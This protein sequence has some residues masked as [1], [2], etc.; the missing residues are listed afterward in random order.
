MQV[1]R[2]DDDNIQSEP[3]KWKIAKTFL[4]GFIRS[5]FNQ[6]RSIGAI[7]TSV[8]LLGL[9][10]VVVC[11]PSPG[12]N[13]SIFKD[14]LREIGFA[15]M[16]SVMMWTIFDVLR[17]KEE[18]NLWNSRIEKISNNVFN[19]VLRKNLPK[20]LISQAISVNL[21]CPLLRG[22]FEGLYE[23]KD[24][25]KGQEYDHDF[26]II[27][28]NVSFTIRNISSE[29]TD[30]QA[31]VSLP[32]QINKEMKSLIRVEKI[33]CT[34]NG[35]VINLD[36]SP[37]DAS[38]EFITSLNKDENSAVYDAGTVFLDPNQEIQV[39]AKYTMTKELEDTEFLHTRTPSKAMK[40]TI[41]DAGDRPRKFFA[42]S[43]HKNPLAD[44]SSDDTTTKIY[45]ISEYVLPYQGI[46]WWWKNDVSS[47]ADQGDDTKSDAE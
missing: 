4:Y 39:V 47:Q 16:V 30:Y 45:R 24:V 1:V 9:F 26:L 36:K 8:F 2:S 3:S 11:K 20:E 41:V 28:S 5:F 6:M 22:D 32:N 37:Q 19:S 21:E 29:K 25:H 43:V 40:V 12:G 15:A 7:G 13:E 35:T 17:K 46:M 42:K 23:I 27:K 44:Q 14:V 38:A 33:E 10:F 31:K 18:E 34:S